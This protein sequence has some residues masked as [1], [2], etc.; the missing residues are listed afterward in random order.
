MKKANT[1]FR[2]RIL[3]PL[4]VALL[5]LL[6]GSVVYTYRLQKFDIS[7]KVQTHLEEVK[8]IIL[9]YLSGNSQE[10]SD[11]INFVMRDRNIQ[12][13]WI[14]GDRD[15]LLEHTQPV[16]EKFYREQKITHLYF[17]D[18]MGVCFLRAHKP[19][20]FGDTINRYT[21]NRA[22]GGA[23]STGGTELGPFGTLT[24]R[25][26]H[27]WWISGELKG[28]V[29][30]GIDIELLVPRLEKI[31]DS[32]LLF[33]VDKS[34]L[35][36]EKWEEGLKFVGRTGDWNQ[37]SEFVIANNMQGGLSLELSKHFQFHIS[38][39]EKDVF[40]VS[41]EDQKYGIGFIPLTDAGGRTIGDIIVLDDITKEE[42]MLHL[43]LLTMI[44]ASAIIGVIMFGFFF[45]F[46]GRIERRLSESHHDLTKEIA[47]RKRAEIALHGAHEKLEVRVQERTN[48]LKR[49]NEQLMVEL[50]ER[51]K[52]EDEIRHLSQRLLSVLEEER[53]GLARDLHDEFGQALTM[54]RFGLESLQGSLPEEFKDEK[55]KCDELIRT[56]AQQRDNISKIVSELRPD[57]L[58]DL[59]FIPTLEWYIED[60]VKQKEDLKIEFKVIGVKKRP[61]PEIEIMLYRI[62]QESLTNIARYSRA[63]NVSV[64]LTASYPDLIFSIKDDGVGFDQSGLSLPLE[65]R[66]TGI[67]LIGIRERVAAVGGTVEIRSSVGKGTTIRIELL[68]F[69]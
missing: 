54:L 64:T 59:G 22:M 10:L 25:V 52:A 45:L 53:K 16:F 61:D 48:D 40:S 36:R 67:G 28:Y 69:T 47:E 11:I 7:K 6:S 13:D 31:F 49:A 55:V 18:L 3:I 14:A 60:F 29:E 23:I 56:V 15:A 42:S 58:D 12:D 21:L 65:S 38:Q 17:I 32:R 19:E 8:H 41:T 44:S 24:L 37:F 43:R 27:P 26:V 2:K 20:A 63:Q 9:A 57:M 35:N 1:K 33:T 51:K 50:A 39:Q 68:A 46:V 5:L 62:L 30:I 34:Y 4:L 66:Q